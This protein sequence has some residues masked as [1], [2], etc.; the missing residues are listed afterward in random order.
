MLQFKPLTGARLRVTP[1]AF[2]HSLN[3]I[4]R[5][6]FAPALLVLGDCK[7]AIFHVRQ[8]IVRGVDFKG[9]LDGPLCGARRQ[10][11]GRRSGVALAARVTGWQVWRVRR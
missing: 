11:T 7:R 10:L 4:H 3:S 6:S 8:E 9:V 2:S 5:H 1:S